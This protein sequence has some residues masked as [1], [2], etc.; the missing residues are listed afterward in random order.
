M[1]IHWM[2]ESTSIG[3]GRW[4]D[5]DKSRQTWIAPKKQTLAE[6]CSCCLTMS[7]VLD[8][9]VVDGLTV[10]DSSR[11]IGETAQVPDGHDSWRCKEIA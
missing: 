5:G 2:E 4:V 10:L 11:Y 7:F 3:G 8:P 1:M 9:E 6:R